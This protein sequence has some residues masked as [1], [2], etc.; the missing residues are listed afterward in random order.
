MVY[1]HFMSLL[2]PQQF[3]SSPTIS[4]FCTLI[5]ICS[6][7]VDHIYWSWLKFCLKASYAKVY[8]YSL[9]FLKQSYL[10]FQFN[11]KKWVKP[12]IKIKSTFH[13]Q[14][15]LRVIYNGSWKITAILKII[16]PNS[17]CSKALLISLFKWRSNR[18]CTIFLNQTV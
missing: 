6:M 5:T 8:S 15:C 4:Q 1:K 2:R 7:Y 3:T 18:W 11:W 16:L 14:N 9:P 13:D 10:N 12:R 17:L